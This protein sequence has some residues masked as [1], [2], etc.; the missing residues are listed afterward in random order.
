MTLDAT[1]P[2]KLREEIVDLIKHKIEIHRPSRDIEL[3]M[4]E[5]AYKIANATLVT[6]KTQEVW[7]VDGG[8][9]KTVRF[10]KTTA[11]L[12]SYEYGGRVVPQH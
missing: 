10:N 12:D 6:P 1:T 11:T 9:F 4:G 5:V 2:E 8:V 3:V 7:L